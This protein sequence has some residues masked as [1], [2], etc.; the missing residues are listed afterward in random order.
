MYF[1][2]ATILA[3]VAVPGCV[4]HLVA[5][6]IADPGVFSLIL[7]RPHTFLE[8]DHEIF[9]MVI[10]LLLLIQE[11]LLSV[12]NA[13]TCMYTKCWLTACPGKKCG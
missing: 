11:G 10:L 9:S 5:S 1:F 4:A 12:T 8:I 6:P 3:D 2:I 13:N 7:V